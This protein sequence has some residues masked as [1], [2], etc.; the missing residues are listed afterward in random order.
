MVA[1]VLTVP[2]LNVAGFS[3]AGPVA[4]SYYSLMLAACRLAKRFCFF[5]LLYRGAEY[6]MVG[7]FAAG[8]QATIGNVAA[9]S[10]F[11]TAQAT[12]MGA[13]T[14][15]VAQVVGGVVTGVAGVVAALI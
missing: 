2:L 14:P 4:G 10:L 11:A 15:L 9:G 13:G 7:T 8:M 12:A 3:A 1:P 6:L 5:F